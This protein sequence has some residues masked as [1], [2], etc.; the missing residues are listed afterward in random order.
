MRTI[1]SKILFV[2]I[3][4]LI[5]ITAMVTTIAVIITHGIIHKD[6]DRILNNVAEKDAAQ[7]NDMLNDFVK[8]AAIMNHYASHELRGR[9]D[10]RDEV[11]LA[12][13]TEQIRHMFDEIALNTSGTSSYYFCFSPELTASTTGF[14]IKFQTDGTIRELSKD[15]FAGLSLITS[16][17]LIAYSNSTGSVKGTWVQPHPSRFT[18]ETVVS[19]VKP[20]Y[21]GSTFIGILGFNMDFSYLLDRVNSISVYE[22]GCAL[23]LSEDQTTYYNLS[24]ATEI[25]G[26]YTKSATPLVCGM[27]LE[28][29]AAYKDIQS[30]IRPM[31]T[32]IV[33]AFLVVFVL[34]ILYTVWV[35]HKI[36]T[37]LKKLT[38]AAGNISSGIQDVDLVV[39]SKDEV[40]IL[41]QV[42]NDTYEK[43]REYSTYIN[44]L[45][46]RDS[47][48]GIKNSTAYSEA[49][50][51]YNK[52]INLDNPVFGVL[53]ADINNLKKTND[54][55]GHDIGNELIV[56][57]ARILTETFKKSSVFRIGGD[58]F[59]VIL[60]GNDLDKCHTLIEKMDAAFAEDYINVNE[61][62]VPVSIARGVAVYDPVV[63]KVYNDVFERADHAMY[64]NKESM[65]SSMD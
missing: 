19:Y 28:L 13:Y 55:Y 26:E 6:A 47:L 27:S 7:I 63:D 61:T 30:G 53:V 36:V 41:S 51:E 18:G 9:E 37:P 45:A 65:K 34:A 50:V 52:D 12:E 60:K 23:L 57:S 46:Y 35:T 48:T 15:E 29:R 59:V 24:D 16:D 20:V 62:N 4:A 40:G 64:I 21:V 42:L 33:G 49:V 22:Y 10:L 32:Y 31:L 11:Y 56:H 2:V 54:T 8:S 43:I 17:E 38:A 39:D 1:Q 14:Y 25:K 58:E 5:V 44:A 3:T